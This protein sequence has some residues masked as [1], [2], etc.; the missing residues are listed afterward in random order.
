MKEYIVKCETENCG[1]KN[2][3]IKVSFEDNVVVICGVCSK[4]ITDIRNI[5]V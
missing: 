4:E 1:N 2:I 5:E 3:E